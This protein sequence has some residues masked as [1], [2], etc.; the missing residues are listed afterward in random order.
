MDR[1]PPK[2]PRRGGEGSVGVVGDGGAVCNRVGDP[3]VGVG[4]VSLSSSRLDKTGLGVRC[5]GDAKG[6]VLERWVSRCVGVRKP[7]VGDGK[8]NGIGLS[9]DNRNRFLLASW[10]GATRGDCRVG[11]GSNAPNVVSFFHEMSGTGLTA[12]SVGVGG[13]SLSSSRLDKTGLGVRCT[14]DAKGGV[15][16][17]WVSRCVG[18]RKPV[19]GDG[20]LNGIGLSSDN[21]NRFLLASWQGATRGDCRVGVGGDAPNVVSFFHML[22]GIGLVNDVTRGGY[23]LLWDGVWMFAT[24]DHRV[25]VTGGQVG[26]GVGVPRH[27]V[28]DA[29]IG[30]PP[31]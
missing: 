24:G 15:L 25:G 29:V 31:T 20:K 3:S 23:R 27:V 14:G 13:V 12:S 30:V 16:E 21:R 10:Q 26:C 17:R 6:G 18:V 4:G 5:T 9:S 22:N 19:V 7:V 8:L 2:S 11:V 1:D 28:G